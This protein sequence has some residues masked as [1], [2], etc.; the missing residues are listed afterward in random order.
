MSKQLRKAQL[1]TELFKSPTATPTKTPRK[2]VEKSGEAFTRRRD[3]QSSTTSTATPKAHKK[4]DIFE[5]LDETMILSPINKTLV[6]QSSKTPQLKTKKQTKAAKAKH[7]KLLKSSKKKVLKSK[8]MPRT[9]AKE[10]PSQPPLKKGANNKGHG[11]FQLFADAGRVLAP[12][13]AVVFAVV[14]SRSLA[15]T[16]AA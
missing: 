5:Y 8:M 11:L 12:V 9:P 2:M 7:R 1:V 16:A 15:T 4:M 3:S 13:A 14:K 6:S 10:P